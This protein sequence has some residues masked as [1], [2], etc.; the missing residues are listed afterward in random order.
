MCYL[1]ALPSLL[2]TLLPLSASPPSQLYLH[3]VEMTDAGIPAIVHA[4]DNF[5]KLWGLGLN[6]NAGEHRVCVG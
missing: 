6:G 1:G 5:P 2:T 4:L 3:G